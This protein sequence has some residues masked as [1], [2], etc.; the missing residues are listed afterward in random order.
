MEL[1][2]LFTAHPASVGESYWTHLLRAASFG[3]RMMLAGGACMVHAIF[4]F[5][6]VTTG[7]SAITELHAAMVTGRRVAPAPIRGERIAS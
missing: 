1:S 6:F 5:L 2:H 4:P 3:S 7:S